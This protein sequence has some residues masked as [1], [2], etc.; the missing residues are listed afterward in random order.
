MQLGCDNP[1][2]QCRLGEMGTEHSLAAKDLGIMVGWQLDVRQ[3][4][5]LTAQK[6]N[7]ILG[8]NQR[9]VARALSCGCPCLLQG[10]WIRWS[11]RVP[12]QLKPFYYSNLSGYSVLVKGEAYN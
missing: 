5:T 11:L 2:Y 12:I 6:A 9:N 8:C 3:Q 10:N 4:C 7:W 1:C